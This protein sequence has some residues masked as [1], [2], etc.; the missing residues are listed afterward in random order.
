MLLEPTPVPAKFD[1]Y[2]DLSELRG[3]A[4]GQPMG[5]YPQLE[6][7]WHVSAEEWDAMAAAGVIV[8]P[9]GGHEVW[10]HPARAEAAR[11]GILLDP[12]I[13]HGERI[14]PA[15]TA[16]WKEQGLLV[17]D[18]GLPVHPAAR[19]GVT[20][21]LREE[22][23]GSEAAQE[24][25][26]GMTT[27]LGRE[28]Y[29]G[30]LNIGNI[31][32]MRRNEA[33]EPEYA[34]VTT[35]RYHKGKTIH[36]ESF[37]G[38]YVER[39]ETIAEGCFREG[40]QEAGIEAGCAAAGVALSSLLDQPHGL[41]FLTPAIDDPCTLNAWLAEHFLVIDASE[42][43]NIQS[44]ALQTFDSAEIKGVRWEVAQR[45]LADD[46]KFLLGAHR[47]ILQA[48]IATLEGDVQ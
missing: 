34:V 15:R 4:H 24:F 36:M 44:V 5:H 42:V 14:D 33:G 16:A 38:G 29:Y 37:P 48:H 2:Y 10:N 47:R 20:T 7:R 35:E 18:R 41:W 40:N 22:M 31:A 23:H 27:G 46:S 45:L 12:V 43:P 30:A 8:V 1:R 13:R 3:A 28:W 39:G 21:V 17:T 9:P 26:L 6:D 32:L 19:L 11:E 25:E